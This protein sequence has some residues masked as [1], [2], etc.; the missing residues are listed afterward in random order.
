VHFRCVDKK[1]KTWNQLKSIY[2]SIKIYITKTNIT[3]GNLINQKWSELVLQ[4]RSV[5]KKFPTLQLTQGRKVFEIRPMIEWDK[6]K[7]LEFLLESLGEYS[8]CC[9]F[10]FLFL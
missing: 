6:G 1:V 9:Y 5:L 10:L 7:A 2:L 4:V 8:S 3:N